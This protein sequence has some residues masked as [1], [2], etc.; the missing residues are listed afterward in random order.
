MKSWFQFIFLLRDDK[1]QIVANGYP[2]LR[3]DSIL[4]CTVEGFNM[5]VLL[6]PF[7]ENFN[8]PS[9]PIKFGNGYS[10]NRKIVGK[11]AIDLTIPKIFINNSNTTDMF[12]I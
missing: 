12:T 2:Y 5:Q 8:L 4:G 1:Q 10:I 6:D 7:E 3:I 11:E 9:F